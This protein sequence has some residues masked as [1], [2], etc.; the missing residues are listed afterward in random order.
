MK[1][2]DERLRAVIN[3]GLR[4]QRTNPAVAADVQYKPAEWTAEQEA[5][6]VANR[7]GTERERID[8]LIAEHNERNRLR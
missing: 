2:T 6:L 1:M 3:D 4:N 7:Y 5:E 8:K